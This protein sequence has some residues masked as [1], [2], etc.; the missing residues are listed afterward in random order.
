M[1]NSV[2]YS[3]RLY[4]FTA[5]NTIPTIAKLNLMGSVSGWLLLRGSNAPHTMKTR[6]NVQKNSINKDCMV[7]RSGFGIVVQN[8]KSL[9][10]PW[11][12]IS[13]GVMNWNKSC[14]HAF[15][16]KI[17]IHQRSSTVLPIQDNDQRLNPWDWENIS[18]QDSLRVYPLFWKGC[19]VR[20]FD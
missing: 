12:T 8:P 5:V 2:R 7:V 20:T 1:S 16:A 6:K 11:N 13:W 19:V 15:S 17:S 18:W 9:S 3:I 14:R 4:V 10:T